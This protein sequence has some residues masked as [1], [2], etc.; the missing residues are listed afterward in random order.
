MSALGIHNY[1]DE[2]ESIDNQALGNGNSARARNNSLT[3]STQN[4]I[5][6]KKNHKKVLFGNQSQNENPIILNHVTLTLNIFNKKANMLPMWK[7]SSVKRKPPNYNYKN[8][9]NNNAKD[10][11]ERPNTRY[12]ENSFFL[13]SSNQIESFESSLNNSES[14]FKK[15]EPTQVKS[16][17]LNGSDISRRY[18]SNSSSENDSVYNVSSFQ[19][20]IKNQYPCVSSTM[21]SYKSST[22][23]T[24]AKSKSGA[25]NFYIDTARLNLGSSMSS[26]DSARNSGR[27]SYSVAEFNRFKNNLLKSSQRLESDFQKHDKTGIKPS[28]NTNGVAP[29][30]IKSIYDV[31][32]RDRRIKTHSVEARRSNYLNSI[33][34]AHSFLSNSL[35]IKKL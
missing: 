15:F 11:K 18:S 12:S 19:N 2:I 31:L 22:S 23:N 10:I 33:S 32:E 24:M 26:N 25:N 21:S 34:K 8:S 28:L 13:T 35:V 20:K 27:H 14:Q 16:A 30:T 5:T 1:D 4:E 29:S 3:E 6:R 7:Y 17:K 9:S